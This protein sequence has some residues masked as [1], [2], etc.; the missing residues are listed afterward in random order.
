MEVSELLGRFSHPK[1]GIK[2]VTMYGVPVSAW[3]SEI[4]FQ[5]GEI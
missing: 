2:R 4:P 5:N 1:F 3:V